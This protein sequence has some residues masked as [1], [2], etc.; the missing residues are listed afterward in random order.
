MT[1]LF[2]SFARKWPRP[3]IP[4]IGCPCVTVAYL[5]AGVGDLSGGIAANCQPGLPLNLRPR[6]PQGRCHSAMSPSGNPEAS[7]REWPSSPLPGILVSTK[8][9]LGR[10]G[11]EA[12]K[13]VNVAGASDPL[14]VIIVAALRSCPS[15]G[16]S[17]SEVTS[18]DFRHI[19]WAEN[20]H[21]SRPSKWLRP[22]LSG[23]FG[24]NATV[25]SRLLSRFGFVDSY[26]QQRTPRPIKLRL[27]F[28]Q[29]AP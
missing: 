26:H 7:F 8:R 11:M 2:S 20:E 9:I 16:H 18:F 28:S 15:G 29:L 5:R 1:Q 12:V 13:S 27:A 24:S 4:R 6:A 10:P 25:S 21:F 22:C 14:S 3:G 23:S 19:L 17:S